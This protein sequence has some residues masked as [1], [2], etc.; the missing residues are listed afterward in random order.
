MAENASERDFQLQETAVCGPEEY[1]PPQNGGYLGSVRFFKHLILTVLALAILIPTTLSIILG[2]SLTRTKAKLAELQENADKAQ[3]SDFSAKEQSGRSGHIVRLGVSA[4]A[5]GKEEKPELPAYQALYPDLYAQPAEHNSVDLEKVVYLSFD[6][7]PSERT[8]ELLEVLEHYNVKATFFVVGRDSEKG[9]QWLRDIVDAGHAI[10]V[11]SY[12]HDYETIYSSV[13]AFLDD[14]AQEYSLILDATGVSPQ[15]FRFPGGSIN[16]YN[17]H[18]YQ[19]IISEMTRRGFVYFDWNRQT[20]DAV[21][22]NV[23]AN[24]LVKNALDQASSMRRIFLLAH[25]NACLTNVVE[26]LPC[27]IEGYQEAGFTFGLLTPEV[28]PVIYGYSG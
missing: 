26:A 9:R 22:S 23:S 3:I 4:E 24:R 13:E 20:G 25:D 6:D 1:P 2:I 7:G 12:T 18:I 19:E 21:Q 5:S 8:P 28:K 16:V 27:I 17:R 10:G 14:F 15:I 11:H